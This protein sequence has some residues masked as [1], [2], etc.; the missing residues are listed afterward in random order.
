M[1]PKL[2][3]RYKAT[4]WKAMRE[5]ERS[6]FLETLKKLPPY[7]KKLKAIKAAMKAW[8]RELREWFF[9]PSPR[10]ENLADITGR[11]FKLEKRAHEALKEELGLPAGELLPG[12][13]PTG[14]RE[15]KK[16]RR[17]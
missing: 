6:K 13:L 11:L 12:M 10:D 3:Y 4:E 16:L 9:S 2:K 1:K 17:K 7:G 14:W 5:D 8:D 15:K